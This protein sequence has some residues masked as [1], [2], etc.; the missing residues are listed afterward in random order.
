[1]ESLFGCQLQAKAH[2]SMKLLER[3]NSQ[4]PCVHCKAFSQGNRMVS[5]LQGDV[6]MDFA[7]QK[8]QSPPSFNSGYVC[9]LGFFFKDL[10][11]PQLRHRTVS[12]RRSGE[13][14]QTSSA[15]TKVPKS[16]VA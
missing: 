2:T 10:S 13:D 7:A 4:L 6:K 5:R 9:G 15:G 16:R 3:D 8:H 14:S 12:G 11:A 1:M